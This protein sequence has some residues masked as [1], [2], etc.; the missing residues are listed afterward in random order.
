LVSDAG[1]GDDVL[2]IMH[3]HYARVAIDE[4]EYNRKKRS[5]ES[6]KIRNE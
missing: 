5:C 1:S 3:D 4:E 2:E 6:D